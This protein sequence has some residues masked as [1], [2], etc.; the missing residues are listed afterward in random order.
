MTTPDFEPESRW[1]NAHS[2]RLHYVDYGNAHLPPLLLLHGLQDCSRLWDLFA[3]H[4]R[5]R[6]HVMALD[7][8]GHGDSP[9]AET[10][11]LDDY[12]QELAGVIEA[13][14]LRDLTLMGHSAGGK[15]SF[16]YAAGQPEHLKRLVI[17]D[18]DPDAY[19]PGS[20]QMFTRYTT[21]S[22]D[23][24]DLEA[25]VQRLRSRQP[26]SSQA[27]LEHNARQM[28]KPNASGGLTWKRDRTL[29][30][31]YER[32]DAWDALPKIAVPTLIVRGAH[33][34][35]LTAPVAVR[36]QAAIPQCTLV[37]VAGG[38]HWV[39]LEE[40]EAFARTLDVYL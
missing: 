25:V 18:M 22:D 8:R 24:A 14:D 37:E 35:L 13:L 10:Y 39:H 26:K 15:N 29:V 11:H 19:N 2:L 34:P 17:L 7:S 38:G 36:M 30:T 28:T 4:M 27:V 6:F 31:K 21:E 9:W 12:V 23:Y 40:P 32:P 20:A 1:I 33:S 16:M 3:A 5:G